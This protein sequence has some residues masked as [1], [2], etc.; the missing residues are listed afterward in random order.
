[1]YQRP[2]LP[3]M[4]I[5][6][7]QQRGAADTSR[8]CRVGYDRIIGWVEGRLGVEG[9]TIDGYRGGAALSNLTG[10]EWKLRDFAGEAVAIDAWIAFKSDGS[11][12][13]HGDCDRF[14]SSYTEKADEFRFGPVAATRMACADLVERIE[15]LYFQGLNEARYTV[16]THLVLA[17]FAADHSLLATFTRRDFD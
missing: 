11:A 15:R 16:A 14:R 1:M 12:L 4:E 9:S 6:P 8:W 5:E 13:G 17:L 10:S 3:R 7:P 2:D